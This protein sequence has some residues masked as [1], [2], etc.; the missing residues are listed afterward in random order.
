M[1]W[2]LLGPYFFSAERSVKF[3]FIPVKSFI[4]LSVFC[5]PLLIVLRQIPQEKNVLLKDGDIITFGCRGG[6]SIR[7]GGK[8]TEEF[9]EFRYMVNN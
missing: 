2:C 1:L 3:K 4:F 8:T 9:S 6:N 5:N 7:V